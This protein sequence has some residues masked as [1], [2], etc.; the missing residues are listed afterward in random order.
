VEHQF[1][2]V[3]NIASFDCLLSQ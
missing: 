2:E 1:G 3:E